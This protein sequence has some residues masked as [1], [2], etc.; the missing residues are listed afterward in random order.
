MISTLWTRFAG[1]IAALGAL[2][3][4]IVGA[5]LKGRSDGKAI[6]AEEQERHRREAIEA[7]RK[8][9]SE[10]DNLA[11]ADVDARLRQWL[12]KDSR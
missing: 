3:A 12:R 10:I 11:P 4:L 1:Y 7:K 6:M 5:F 2:L 8:L 9:D